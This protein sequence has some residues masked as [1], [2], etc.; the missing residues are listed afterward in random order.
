MVSFI[1]LMGDVALSWCTQILNTSVLFTTRRLPKTPKPPKCQHFNLPPF[2]H[3]YHHF[4][5]IH[6]QVI[7]IVISFTF[8]LMIHGHQVSVL[9]TYM[10]QYNIQLIYMIYISTV[11]ERY[12]QINS[13]RY[14]QSVTFIDKKYHQPHNSHF[15]RSLRIASIFSGSYRLQ[16]LLAVFIFIIRDIPLYH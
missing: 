12:K 7:A 10:I 14:H 16:V 5:L 1:N 6:H 2:H 4:Y 15:R 13:L 9:Y 3:I 8:A 11:L